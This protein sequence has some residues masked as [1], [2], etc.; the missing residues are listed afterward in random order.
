VENWHSASDFIFYGQGG[1][2]RRNELEE[3]EVAMLSLQLIQNCIIYINT[4]IIQQLLSEKEWENRLE[5]ED[6]RAL[7]PMIYS[8]IN[9]YGEFRLDMDKRMAI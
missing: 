3:Q 7:T 8:H 2:I 5:E 6:Y 4:L 1:E 9:P